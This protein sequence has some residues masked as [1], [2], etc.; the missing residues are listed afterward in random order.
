MSTET[1]TTTGFADLDQLIEEA[2]L[3]S[4]ALAFVCV[5]L[6]QLDKDLC[7]RLTNFLEAQ[8]AAVLDADSLPAGY[9]FELDVAPARRLMSFLDGYYAGR[10]DKIGSGLLQSQ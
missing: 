8:L 4:Q 5:R 10:Q 3:A 2:P 6:S 9:D 1:K 7:H